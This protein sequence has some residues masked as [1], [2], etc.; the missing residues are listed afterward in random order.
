MNKYNQRFTLESPILSLSQPSGLSFRYHM[1][2]SDMGNLSLKN[3]AESV[4]WTMSGN[5]GSAWH[6]AMV[7]IPQNTTKLK[8]VG[9]TGSN[10]A[11]DIAI[12]RIQPAVVCSVTDGT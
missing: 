11:S 6:E 8:L 3:Q 10:A 7:A 5:Q 9:E 12:D 1:Y 2:G 4:M